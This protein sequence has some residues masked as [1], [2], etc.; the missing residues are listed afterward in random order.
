MR[1]SCRVRA[2]SVRFLLWI[3]IGPYDIPTSFTVRT[4]SILDAFS[5]S[6]P[7]MPSYILDLQQGTRGLG[8]PQS[9]KT[10]NVFPS[11]SR[12]KTRR[13]DFKLFIP[14]RPD[15][16]SYTK[17]NLNS[18]KRK[19][20]A[21]VFVPSIVRTEAAPRDLNFLSKSA[22]GDGGRGTARQDRDRV[23]HGGA[24]YRTFSRLEGLRCTANRI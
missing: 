16:N 12:G 23:E 1:T 19:T 24:T 9:Q 3:F 22:R 10:L 5:S 17:K 13:A 4:P 18:L 11:F 6:M 2:P 15:Y 14:T 21:S 20:E 7:S 8:N